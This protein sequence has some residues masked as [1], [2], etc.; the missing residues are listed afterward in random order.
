MT[1]D[2]FRA[3]ALSLP[4]TAEAAH[5]NHPDFRVRGTVFA[6]LGYP[7]RLWGMVALSPEEQAHFCDTEPGVF[8]PVKGTWGR[9]GATQVK[10]SAARKPVLR[11]AL[12][13]AWGYRSQQA[14]TLAKKAVTRKRKAAPIRRTPRA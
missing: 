10:L 11:A 5:F 6:T 9:E 13:A 2:D 3:M 4:N 7:S 12:L 8:V 14:A 1:A